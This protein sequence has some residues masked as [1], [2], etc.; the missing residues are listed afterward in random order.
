MPRSVAHQLIRLAD[1][2]HVAVFD[3]VVDHLDVVA[4]PLGA[5]PVAARGAVVDLGGDRLEDRLDVG[6][7][8]GIAAGHD[9]GALQ[10]PFLAAGNPGADEEDPLLLQGA[11]APGG[12]GIVGVAAVDQDV[13]GLEQR[14]EFVDHV[15]DRRPGLDHDHDLA[16]PLQRADQ[17]L[18]GVAADDL[19]SFA[20]DRCTK[21]STFE[22]VRLNTATV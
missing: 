13:A 19:L 3:A 14:R 18:D 2:L 17:F 6:P 7:G 10:R 1:E 20:R 16:R 4:G 5:D 15:V 12:V 8:L 21:S 9:R 22:V 11:G